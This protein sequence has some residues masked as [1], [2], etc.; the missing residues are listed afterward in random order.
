MIVCAGNGE[1]FDFATAIGVGL[2]D[3]AINLTKICIYD[4]P[5]FILFVGSCG[6]YGEKNIFDIIH[7]KSAA[8]IENSFFNANSF[9]PI[10]NL[11]STSSDVS[12]E[13]IVNSSNYITRDVSLGKS[14]LANRIGAENMEFFS[15]MRV[16]QQY[17]IPVGGIFV[18]TNYCDENAHED[19]ITNHKKAKEILSSYIIANQDKLFN[20]ASK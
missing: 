4:R 3:C 20:F 18:V 10:D 1:E 17:E 19:F 7:S 14:Y 15:A 16:A 9:T 13:T 2:V 12:R 6:S 5:K 11:I 8:N